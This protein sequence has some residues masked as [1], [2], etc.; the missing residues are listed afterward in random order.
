MS[1]QALNLVPKADADGPT[2]G[3]GREDERDAFDGSVLDHIVGKAADGGER[4]R[5]TDR[6]RIEDP[7]KPGNR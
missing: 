2:R 1:S 5:T 3:H 7:A 4:A 6:P